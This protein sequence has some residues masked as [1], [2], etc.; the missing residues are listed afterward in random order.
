MS[1][2]MGGTISQATGRH[3]LVRTLLRAGKAAEAIV[4]LCAAQIT[5]PDGLVASCSTPFTRS[6]IGRR[7]WCWPNKLLRQQPDT[8]RLQKA[9]LA[10]LSDM[11]RFPEAIAQALQYLEQHGE[12]LTV[13]DALIGRKF[14]YRQND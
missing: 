4:Q 14:L 7:R 11:K 6:A 1:K 10:T 13:L 8:A 3:N 2:V 9:L 12:D 5:D